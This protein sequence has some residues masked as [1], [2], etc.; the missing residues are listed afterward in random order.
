MPRRGNVLKGRFLT[1]YNSI[2]VTKLINNI[3]L[4]GKMV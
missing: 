4:D 2:L 3:M 1:R